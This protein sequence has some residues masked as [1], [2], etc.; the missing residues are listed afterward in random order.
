[1]ECGRL[2][3]D[4]QEMDMRGRVGPPERRVVYRTHHG[5]KPGGEKEG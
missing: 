3:W 4:R 2:S 5:S 1:M